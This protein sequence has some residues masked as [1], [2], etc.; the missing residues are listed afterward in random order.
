[1]VT[2]L[3]EIADE[4][5]TEVDPIDAPSVPINPA[6]GP[7]AN[8]DGSVSNTAT[9]ANANASGSGNAGNPG[10][11][12]TGDRANAS[13]NFST[14]PRAAAWP[15]PVQEEVS[16]PGS[17]GTV[18]KMRNQHGQHGQSRRCSSG[19]SYQYQDQD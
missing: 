15:A 2:A 11:T 9:G 8:G 18:Q 19:R 13:G 1:M 16:L 7:N 10:N 3:D 5:P 14:T 12:A 6:C 17:I 4:W